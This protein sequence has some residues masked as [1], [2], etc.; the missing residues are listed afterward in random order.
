MKRKLRTFFVVIASLLLLC[1][2]SCEDSKDIPVGTLNISI[3]DSISR[4]IEPNISLD[5][6]KYEVTILNSDGTLKVSKELEIAYM[7]KFI[8]TEVSFIAE[9][10]VDGYIFGHTGNYLAIKMLNC[11][12]VLK[13]NIQAKI[14]KIEYPYCI[15]E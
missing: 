11:E 8:N 5:I 15:A 14:T 9:T 7:T 2:V 10:Y 3:S 6:D 4:A 12:N 1:F 13:K